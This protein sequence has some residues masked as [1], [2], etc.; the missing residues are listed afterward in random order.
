MWMMGVGGSFRAW[1]AASWWR[2][3]GLL[4]FHTPL[5]CAPHSVTWL[6]QEFVVAGPAG[7]MLVSCLCT[8][9][10]HPTDA[11]IWAP[12]ASAR[13]Q[14][15]EFTLCQLAV[16][17]SSGFALVYLLAPS[18]YRPLVVAGTWRAATAALPAH[19]FQRSPPGGPAFTPVQRVGTL[20]LKA[21]QY[22]A[23]G[24]AMGVLG[25]ATVHGLIGLRE[26]VDPGFTPPARVQS[27][28]GVAALWGAFMATNSNVRYK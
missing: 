21:V 27:I 18:I 9:P 6:L 3:P 17:L 13:M 7:V 15:L 10:L 28:G 20:A 24:L 12:L 23:L 22:G 19:V 25:T 8:Q 5:A 1:S 16:S 14:E 4:V 26:R 11:P 2:A